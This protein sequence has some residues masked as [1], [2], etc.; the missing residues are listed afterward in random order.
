[1]RKI[2]LMSIGV[3]AS[4]LWAG[5]VC[6]GP[7]MP[8]PVDAI[9]K[10]LTFAMPAC[11]IE[12]TTVP[13]TTTEFTLPKKDPRGVAISVA[14]TVQVTDQ[15]SATI[16]KI[17]GDAEADRTGVIFSRTVEQLGHINGSVDFDLGCAATD[18]YGS[19]DCSWTWGESIEAAFQ[20][21]LQEDITSGKLLVDLK[22]DNTIPFSFSCPVC[23]A[24]CSIT[25]PHQLDQ[26]RLDE[27]WVLM[28]R[29][30]RFPLALTKTAVP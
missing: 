24:N 25:I 9:T 1:M 15:T 23:G 16:F 11:P 19:N 22:I 12:A 17:S 4:T 26:G 10:T 6:A 3:L 27:I 14:G 30:I 2:N 5:A 20:G 21:A 29:L 7:P 13:R 28:I 8:P 18:P